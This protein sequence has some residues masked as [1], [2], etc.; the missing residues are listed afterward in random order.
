MK[1]LFYF[2]LLFLFSCGTKTLVSDI[3]N[4]DT[5]FVTR[6]SSTKS[7]LIQ[8]HS[9]QDT[10]IVDITLQP[11]DNENF[12]MEYFGC[13]PDSMNQITIPDLGN[14]WFVDFS[15]GKSELL[16]NGSQS[17]ISCMCGNSDQCCG[18]SPGKTMCIP[19]N[20]KSCTSVCLIVREETQSNGYFIQAENLKV[21]F[22]LQ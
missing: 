5:S 4:Y 14:Y 17:S 22:K 8:F 9:R 12:Y 20:K 19:C 11:Q 13:F 18:I 6:V 21:N 3:P 10:S 2:S 16:A 7:A 1:K 15:T